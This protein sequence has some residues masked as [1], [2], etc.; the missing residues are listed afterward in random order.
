MEIKCRIFDTSAGPTAHIYGKVPQYISA[1]PAVSDINAKHLGS[2]WY[3]KG[4]GFPIA[5]IDIWLPERKLEGAPFNILNNFAYHDPGKVLEGKKA[6]VYSLDERIS[7]KLEGE[8][9]RNVRADVLS[10]CGNDLSSAKPHFDS[11]S[12]AILP[13]VIEKKVEIETGKG[14]FDALCRTGVH[15]IDFTLGCVS[16]TRNLQGNITHDLTT[17]CEYCYSFGNYGGVR[18]KQFKASHLEEQIKKIEAEQGKVRF[19]R[20]G[21]NSDPAHEWLYEHNMHLLELGKKHNFG[22]VMVTKYLPFIPGMANALKKTGSVLQYSFGYEEME[23]GPLAWGRDNEFRIENAV[24]YKKAGVNVLTR[25]VQEAPVPPS[26]FAMRIMGLYEN[27]DIP[28][29]FNPLRIMN[30]KVAEKLGKNWNRLIADPKQSSFLGNDPQEGTYTK[31]SG[32]HRLIPR[33]IHKD[34]L[35]RFADPK[36]GG[37]C[38]EIGNIV[39]CAGCG[40][41]PPVSAHEKEAKIPVEYKKKFKRFKGRKSFKLPF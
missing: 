41:F 40:V 4:E 36:K 9:K 21:K 16:Y 7:R 17:G 25:L 5:R 33:K 8:V 2:A 28:T 29:I 39:F 34:F 10:Y 22:V 26:G 23:H 37:I 1:F 38:G 24:R 11:V 30:S 13:V 12:N 32:Q 15:N 19:I 20:L 3:R 27:Y 35:K 14:E 18:L 6:I 31:N